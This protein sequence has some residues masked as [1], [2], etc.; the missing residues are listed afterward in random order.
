L[1]AILNAPSLSRKTAEYY[2]RTY[3]AKRAARRLI[4]KCLALA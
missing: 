4:W 1:V 3:V 2:S